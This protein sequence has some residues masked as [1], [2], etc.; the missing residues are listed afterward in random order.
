MSEPQ[1]PRMAAERAAPPQGD[2]GRELREV[3]VWDRPTRILH[4]LHAVLVTLAV[5]LGLLL[6]YREELHIDGAEAEVALKWVHSFAAYPLLI[7]VALRWSLGFWGNAHVRWS[8][9]WPSRDTLRGAHQELRG[10]LGRAAPRSSLA[11][12][13]LGGL[14]TVL[15]LVLLSIAV[16]TGF[17]RA[18]TDLYFPPLG[19]TVAAYVARD[20]IS[21]T[22]LTPLR[23]DL[24]DPERGGRVMRWKVEI[25]TVHRASA[26]AVMVWLVLHVVGVVLKDARQ[27]GAVLSSMVTGR[28]VVPRAERHADEG[29]A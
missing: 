27:R 21:P 25:G 5:A 17:V 14:S 4:A 15:V 11:H 3:H 26:L 29:S 10:L 12:G 1:L 28:K 20:G 18:S 8:G 6:W 19:G 2:S 16:V 9:L 7:T 13:A 24:L 22:E 23:K